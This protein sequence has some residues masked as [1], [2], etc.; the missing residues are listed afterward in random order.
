MRLLVSVLLLSLALAGSINIKVGKGIGPVNTYDRRPL[1]LIFSDIL[2]NKTIFNTKQG[3]T[4]ENCNLD[5]IRNHLWCFDDP[6]AYTVSIYDISSLESDPSVV[7]DQWSIPKIT[8]LNDMMDMDGLIYNTSKQGV[9]FRES[10][11]IHYY[12]GV[13]EPLGRLEAYDITDYN[14]I[15]QVAYWEFPAVIAG[16]F[17]YWNYENNGS[18]AILAFGPAILPVFFD[19]L[20]QNIIDIGPG[21]DFTALGANLVIPVPYQDRLWVS[22]GSGGLYLF[23]CRDIDNLILLDQIVI[24]GLFLDVSISSRDRIFVRLLLL[25]D[26]IIANLVVNVVNNTLEP[27]DGAFTLNY[28]DCA[29][30]PYPSP[31]TDDFFPFLGTIEMNGVFK[32]LMTFRYSIIVYQDFSDDGIPVNELYRYDSY[33]DELGVRQAVGSFIVSTTPDTPACNCLV[34]ASCFMFPQITKG[35]EYFPPNSLID[36][37]YLPFFPFSGSKI[38]TDFD[39]PVDLELISISNLPLSADGRPTACPQQPPNINITGK[40]VVVWYSNPPGCSLDFS[41]QFFRSY[42]AAGMILGLPYDIQIIY[43]ELNAEYGTPLIGGWVP[44]VASEVLWGQLEPVP[45]PAPQSSP[46]STTVSSSSM[47]VPCYILLMFVISFYSNY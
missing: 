16:F 2:N 19:K 40:V 38:L 18:I 45:E 41:M 35:L 15:V 30:A 27:Y 37:Q 7:S 44:Y 12:I 33:C 11:G 39:P 24:Q 23:D 34:N 20:D 25:P 28:P 36:N 1:G 21:I 47:M 14:A 42:G 17:H 32:V 6:D 31:C 5:P 46:V 9:L 43:G 8:K 3:S 26:S 13:N 4:F 29:G 22:L 10:N